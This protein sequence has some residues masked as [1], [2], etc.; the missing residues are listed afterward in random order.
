MGQSGDGI[1]H[2][3]PGMMP[4]SLNTLLLIAQAELQE[5][6]GNVTAAEVL[7]RKAVRSAAVQSEEGKN[8]YRF[9]SPTKDRELIGNIPRDAS[10]I[11]AIMK[12][13]SWDRMRR[14]A[15]EELNR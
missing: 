12:G 13:D 10:E 1:R 9:L 7:V 11:L 8:G 6:L 14:V 4:W 5:E 3:L 15:E 2:G